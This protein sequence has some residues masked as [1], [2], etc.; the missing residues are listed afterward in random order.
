MHVW[1]P[2][3]DN[4]IEEVVKHCSDCL[5]VAR[6]PSKAITHPWSWPIKPMDRIHLDFCDYGN[7]IYLILVDSYSK[8]M[9]VTLIKKC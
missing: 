4:K 1:F 8:W 3:I 6:E 9:D 5:K 7:K 2:G